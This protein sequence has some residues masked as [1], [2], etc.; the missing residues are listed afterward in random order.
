MSLAK[1]D[2]SPK[3]LLCR[4]SCHSGGQT[5]THIQHLALVIEEGKSGLIL[6]DRGR[7]N[8]RWLYLF[9]PALFITTGKI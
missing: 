3:L 6:I 5:M 8:V 1:G 2:S 9:G 4:S 7:F